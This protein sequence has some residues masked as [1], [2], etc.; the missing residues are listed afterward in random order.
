MSDFHFY[1]DVYRFKDFTMEEDEEVKKWETDK[2]Q[3]GTQGMWTVKDSKS[4]QEED[5]SKHVGR[6]AKIRAQAKEST[7][8]EF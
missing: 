4:H 7:S 5:A 6:I 1:E 8:K 3:Q 2:I